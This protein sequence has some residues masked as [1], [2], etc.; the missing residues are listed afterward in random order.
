MNAIRTYARDN[1]LR[2][3]IAAVI[4]CSLA[5]GLIDSSVAVA[6]VIL[7]VEPSLKDLQDKSEKVFAALQENIKKVQDT[8]NNALEEVKKEGTLHAKTNEELKK[9][10]ETGTKL[11]NDLA[12]L[13]TRTLEVEQKLAK[14]PSGGNEQ[15]KSIA[16]S[17]NDE[18]EESASPAGVLSEL[19]VRELTVDIARR[20]GMPSAEKGVVIAQVRSGGSAE[21]A[22]LKEGDLILEL[23]RR[24]VTSLRS[25]E[26]AASQVA[27]DQPV[28]LLIKRQGRTLY[29]T[30]KS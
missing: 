27:K 11:S 28:L 10:G 22:G 18:P 14:R 4:V 26:S 23:N 5:A 19:D 13:K 30:L 9:L 20:L 17:G 3:G 8:A 15:P 2:L 7:D 12:E 21:E 24:P 16:K 1:W 6:G 29:I 25:Y